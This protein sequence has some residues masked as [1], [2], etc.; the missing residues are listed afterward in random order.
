MN[1]YNS[2]MRTKSLYLLEFDKIL[3]MLS[4]QA[5]SESTRV[6]IKGLLPYK[7]KGEA[8]RHLNETTE[9]GKVLESIGSPPL[10]S[11]EEFDRAM[12]LV[13]KDTMLLPEQLTSVALFLT[14]CRRMKQYLKRG[15]FCSPYMSSFGFSIDPLEPLQQ[16]IERCIRSDSVDDSASP[17]LKDIRRQIGMAGD[18]IR[19]KLDSVLRSHPEWFME[20]FVI[21]R[22]GRYALPVKKECRRM[23]E[24]TVID[25]SQ[26]GSTVFIE[27]SSVRK[28]YDELNELMI[29]EENEIRRIL[30]ML[31]GLVEDN[32]CSIRMNV[33]IMGT[34]DF[35]FAKAKLGASMHARPPRLTEERRIIINNGRHPL[36]ARETV[37]PLKFAIGDGISAVVI[38]GPNTGGKTVALKTVGL[39]SLMAQS[40][41]HVPTDEESLF[42]I[43]SSVLCDIGDGQ[44]IEQNLSTFSSH[45]ANIIEILKEMDSRSL[46]LLDELGSGTDPTEGMGLAIALLEDIKGSGCLLTATTHYPEI[47]D[48]AAK[49]AGFCNARMAFD[50]DTLMPLYRLEI[51]LAGES[52]ALHIAERLGLPKRIVERAYIA[53]YDS[54]KSYTGANGSGR[55]WIS[56]DS[57]LFKL[58]EIDDAGSEPAE[59]APVCTLKPGDSIRIRASGKIGIV[60]ATVDDKGDVGVQVQDRKFLIN[61]KRIR[62]LTP[63]EDLYPDYPNYDLSIVLD[64]VANRKARHRM[65]KRHIEGN[66][67]IYDKEPQT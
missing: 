21:Q 13:G 29:Q 25:T 52:C 48:F 36:L 42:C 11:M 41:L 18:R 28:A 30:Y 46:V 59:K 24:G 39:L 22:N 51:G 33:D 12:S 38:T 5:V 50:Q 19:Q 56:P 32:T 64:S 57:S 54:G 58:P 14:S 62:L 1:C 49:T 45:M 9:A 10:S 16:E 8:E 67:I 53:A 44:S 2:G 63:A 26:T 43:N 65:G 20:A 3:D 55:S 47:K 66:E 31:T 60:Y 7:D 35:L 40:G 15:E 17:Q 37:V 34:L 4:A 23:V 27:P 6:K 61:H